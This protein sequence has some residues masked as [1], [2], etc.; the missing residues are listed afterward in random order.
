VGT[1]ELLRAVPVKCS[2]NTA[3]VCLG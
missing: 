3:V 1:S 2:G